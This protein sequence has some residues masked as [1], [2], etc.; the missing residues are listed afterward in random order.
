M[1]SFRESCLS[2]KGGSPGLSLCLA[3]STCP[4]TLSPPGV[5][6]LQYQP[7]PRAEEDHTLDALDAG[8]HLR[9]R[10]PL[11]TA[12]PLHLQSP[13]AGPQSAGSG[14]TE[15]RDA[16]LFQW[17]HQRLLYRRWAATPPLPGLIDSHRR[18]G[19]PVSKVTAEQ[20]ALCLLIIFPSAIYTSNPTNAQMPFVANWWERVLYWGGPMNS[21]L[22][23]ALPSYQVQNSLG[24]IYLVSENTWRKAQWSSMNPLVLN[25]SGK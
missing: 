12:I 6:T 21:A 24:E 8:Q 18:A 22:R 3:I 10:G 19:E 2:L 15:N 17:R 20:G 5:P 1:W 13:P 23:I 11:W 9:Q 14:K 4:P 7:M 25:V 16:V